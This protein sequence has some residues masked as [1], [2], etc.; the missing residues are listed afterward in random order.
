MTKSTVER[1][2]DHRAVV[3]A[4][5]LSILLAACGGGTT[6]TVLQTTPTPKR[7]TPA[8]VT[9]SQLKTLASTTPQPIFWSG[10]STDT[11][12]LTRVADGRTYI[13]YLPPGVAVGSP[14]LH[15][16]IGTYVRPVSPYSI[17]KAA[18]EQRHATMRFLRD[19]SLAVV[20]PSRPQS[21]YLVFPGK[22][23][24]IEVYDPSP[25]RAMRLV[26][27]GKIVPLA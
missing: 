27:S 16:T 23:Y 12:E 10:P 18:A 7:A 22:S 20:Y 14:T 21:V 1:R 13:R 8:A 4:A 6:T 5:V 19:G 26:L 3:S 9:E 17:V 2:R 25:A 11:Y 15:L 24:E